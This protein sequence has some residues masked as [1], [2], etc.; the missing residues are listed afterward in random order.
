MAAGVIKF[1]QEYALNLIT[2]FVYQ[3]AGAI[4]TYYQ[5]VPILHSQAGREEKLNLIYSADILF[6]TILK[7]LNFRIIKKCNMNYDKWEQTIALIKSSYEVEN[8]GKEDIDDL[9]IM[10]FIEFRKAGELFRL[11]LMIK[12]KVKEK[13]TI[14]SRRIG[15]ETSEKIIYD[16]NEKVYVLKV[17]KYNQ[18]RMNG[19]KLIPRL[20]KKE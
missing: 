4:N 15:S 3:F 18:G 2:D 19:R 10:E 11:E 16:E 7:L 14:Y 17:Y 9:T 1:S 13:K 8:E 12:P 6:E 20:F 5:S